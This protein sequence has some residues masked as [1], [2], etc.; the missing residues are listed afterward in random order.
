VLL[1]NVSAIGSPITTDMV[2]QCSTLPG[3]ALGKCSCVDALQAR[4]DAVSICGNVT[5]TIRN[6]CT[7]PTAIA[8]ASAVEDGRISRRVK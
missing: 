6:F 1:G 5:Q 8:I 4:P 2:G 3:P 7:H